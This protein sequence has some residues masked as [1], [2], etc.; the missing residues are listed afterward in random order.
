MSIIPNRKAFTLTEVLLAIV[1]IGI[2]AIFTIP[3]LIQS[4][5]ES[6]YKVAWKQEFSALN[7]ATLRI[8]ANNGGTMKDAFGN[9]EFVAMV[10]GYAQ[11]MPAMKKC[12]WT[13]IG[14]C[15]HNPGEWKQL[16]NTPITYT[17]SV[18]S[19]M[20]RN[21]GSL[22][23]FFGYLANCSN[24]SVSPN[25][26]VCAILYID[27]NGFKGPNTVGKDIYRA[28]IVP[29]GLKPYGTDG[30]YYKGSCETTGFGCAAKYLYQ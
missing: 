10:N 1:I 5:Q 16:D 9:G 4:V 19:C 20:I 15:W 29:D 25:Y 26:T 13:P 28:Y 17:G 2:V 11:Y 21:N 7:Q 27:I 12:G 23:C 6:R 22:N 30:D 18:G 24:T 8:M 14:V 3:A